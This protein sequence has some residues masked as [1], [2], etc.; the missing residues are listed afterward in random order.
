MPKPGKWTEYVKYAFGTF[1]LLLALYYGYTAYTIYTVKS[2]TTSAS[3]WHT[4]LDSAL[5]ESLK[6]GKPVII[7]FWATWCKNCMVM[8]KRVLPEPEV[9]EKLNS[10]VKAKF[11]A[12]NPNAPEIREVL[13]HFEILG[14]PSF[15]ILEPKNKIR[16]DTTTQ[17]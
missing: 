14:L 1:L 8:N 11:Q 12:E 5:E 10:F 4:S 9:K 6:T 17:K 16:L 7:D 13:D 15:I 3:D 2:E